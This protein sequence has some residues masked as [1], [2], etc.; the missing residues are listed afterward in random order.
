MLQF[1]I[2]LTLVIV[3]P[4]IMSLSADWDRLHPPGIGLI[5]FL[6][7]VPVIAIIFLV[8]RKTLLWTT[9]LFLFSAVGAAIGLW[10]GFTGDQPYETERLLFVSSILAGLFWWFGIQMK[11][12]FT[13]QSPG[14][15]ELPSND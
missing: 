7:L 5:L 8:D 1:R 12:R 2:G 9:F 6:C 3:V 14:I 10:I 15:R 13:R 4:L 11:K